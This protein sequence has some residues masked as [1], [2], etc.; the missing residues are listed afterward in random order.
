MAATAL[1]KFTQGLNVGPDGEALVGEIGISVYL[2]NVDNTDVASW[3]FDLMYADPGSALYADIGT[4]F[5]SGSSSTPAAQF[6][7]DVPGSY[8]WVLNVWSVPGQVGAPSSVDIR[9]FSVAEA[10]GLIVPPPQL[11]PLPLPDPRSGAPTA[12]PNEMNFGGQP[13]GWAGAG[14]G[15]KLLGDVV[16]RISVPP[17]VGMGTTSQRNALVPTEGLR[18][19]NTTTHAYE[20]YDGTIWRTVVTVPS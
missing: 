3:R 2:S 16:R 7:P 11:W 9:V 6:T 12:K 15:D 10:N 14:T 5:A 18:W 19:Y 4:D 1:I 8:R 13:F 17:P 20:F